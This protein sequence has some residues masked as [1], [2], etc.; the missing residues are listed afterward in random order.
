MQLF[1]QIPCYNEAA[2]LPVTLAKIPRSV[3]GCRD[4]KVL[5]IDDGSTDNTI[6][7]ARQNGAD[8]IV[9]MTS[10]QGLA[11]AFTMGME[12]SVKLGADIIVNTDADNQYNAE[13][14]NKLT[15]PITQ[16]HA[17][18]VIGT[19]PIGQIQHF[20]FTKKL[21]QNIG[22]AIVRWISGVNIL[23][24][25]SGFRALNREAALKINIFSKYTYTLEM[26]IQAKQK[27]LTVVSVPIRV[28][29]YLR[30]SRL[31]KSTLSYVL[32]SLQTIIRISVNYHPF[33]FFFSIGT[34]FAVIGSLMIIR[35]LWLFYHHSGNGHVQSLI[36]ASILLGLGFQIILTAFITDVSAI[37]R[38]IME[39]VQYRLK[40]DQLKDASH[41]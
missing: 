9:K 26:L 29:G 32:N 5:I 40:K 3:T 18:I 34:F 15:A 13:D 19:R 39:D 41:E 8:H 11:R 38:R 6:E 4:V 28:N 16:K 17:D 31:A 36:A 10:H 23:D 24:A 25:T 20:S 14:I 7:V 35:F 1:I 30:P 22:S 27:N 33:R 21:L 2:T 12:A 37:N